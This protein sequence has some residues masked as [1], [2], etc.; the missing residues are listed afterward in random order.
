[1]EPVQTGLGEYMSQKI[2]VCSM[3]DER[4]DE[5]DLKQKKEHE[6]PEPQSG[7]AREAWLK[8]GLP[9]AEWIEQTWEGGC[10]DQAGEGPVW[11]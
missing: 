1:M 11:E 7:P 8:S 4:F 10:W 9:Y 6:H 3:C 2:R 5:N